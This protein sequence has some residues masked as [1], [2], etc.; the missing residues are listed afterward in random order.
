MTAGDKQNARGYQIKTW[1]PGKKE[2][3][4]KD[5]QRDSAIR[6]PWMQNV[7][8]IT[9]PTFVFI[10]AG[11]EEG[12]VAPDIKAQFIRGDN[13][14]VFIDDKDHFRNFA[15][16]YD[17]SEGIIFFNSFVTASRK[18]FKKL[19]RLGLKGRIAPEDDAGF[20]KVM[21]EA[22]QRVLSKTVSAAE[23][24]AGIRDASSPEHDDERT[25]VE[26]KKGGIDLNPAMTSV[27]IQGDASHFNMHLTPIKIPDFPINGLTPV[28][29][30]IA[31]ITN[32]NML[33]G[34]KEEA[35]EFRQQLSL[36]N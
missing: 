11:I 28:I 15:Y 12:A 32:I 7:Q 3:F 16:V 31:P 25:M 18:A 21:Q 19:L 13:T 6:I 2:L 33:L 4:L 20:D 35:D 8:D 10:Q 26:S 29:I 17:N 27:E 9:G 1:T 14:A 30:N 24:G 34:I 23:A 22:K 36:V 5:I